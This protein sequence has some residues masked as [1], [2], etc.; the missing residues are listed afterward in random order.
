MVLYRLGLLLARP[1]G[2]IRCTLLAISHT[3]VLALEVN[4]VLANFT[5]YCTAVLD[6]LTAHI[7][8]FALQVAR[9]GPTVWHGVLENDETRDDSMNAIV[10]TWRGGSRD[11][12]TRR[13]CIVFAAAAAAVSA[14]L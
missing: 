1:T 2:S 14:A 4:A 5:A 12:R 11:I 6:T 7:A 9:F 3:E 8:E 10:I 13:R